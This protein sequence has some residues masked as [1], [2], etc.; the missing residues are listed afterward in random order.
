MVDLGQVYLARAIALYNE[1]TEKGQGGTDAADK[2]ALALE[3]D[4]GQNESVNE[5]FN[6]A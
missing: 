6:L 2:D 5:L 3:L 4:R 1:S